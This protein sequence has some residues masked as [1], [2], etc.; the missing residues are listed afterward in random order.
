MAVSA[1]EVASVVRRSMRWRI[2]D[3]WVG[4]REREVSRRH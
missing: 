2:S 3:R 4:E 1:R